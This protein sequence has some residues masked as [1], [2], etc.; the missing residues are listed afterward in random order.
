MLFFDDPLTR[1]SR[2]RVKRQKQAAF[3]LTIGLVLG[4][5]L[6]NLVMELF[7]GIGV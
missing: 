4:C 5:G 1:A 3:N 6:M 7:K 2:L